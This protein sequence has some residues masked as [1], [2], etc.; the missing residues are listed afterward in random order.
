MRNDAHDELDNVPSL[1][2]GRDRD[3]YPAPEFEPIRKPADRDPDSPRTRQKRRGGSTAPLWTLIVA[4]FG[5]LV[6]LGW[7]S[8]Q[9]VSKLEAQLVATQESFAR[10]S[11]D[12]SGRLQDISGKI[13]ATESNVTTEGEALKLRIKQL[14]KQTLELAEQQRA[15]TTQQ[16]SL[17]GKQG[18]QDKRLDEQN[19]RFESVA[20]EVR[21]QQSAAATL[22]ETVKNVSGEQAQLKS[23]FAGLKASVDELGK[24][25]ARID[26][27]SKDVAALKQRGDASQAI[28]RLE[29]DVLIL[30]SELD[31]RPAATPGVNTSEFD[32][33]RAQMTR[34]VNTLQGQIANLQQQLDQR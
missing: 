32:A 17:T 26:G 11:E 30:R 4:L 19:T 14:E 31:N 23:S 33:F 29:Q 9:Q 21:G 18:N 15:I 22:A 28:S 8:M 34:N 27:L 10:I 7:W 2:A 5:L 1:T 25:S 6:A 24:L 12:A 13:V 3:P 16:Q 20:N